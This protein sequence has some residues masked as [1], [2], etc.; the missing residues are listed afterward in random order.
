MQ[1]DPTA[2]RD[3]T[4][5]TVVRVVQR[6][7]NVTGETRPRYEVVRRYL[8]TGVKH[9]SLYHQLLD[10]ATDVWHARYVVVDSTGV[11][12]GLSSFLRA[13]L[14]DRVVM[15]VHFSLSSKSELG[16]NFLG[17]IDSGRFK[18]YALDNVT[19]SDRRIDGGSAGFSDSR[20]R[21]RSR[22]L[23]AGTRMHI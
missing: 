7:D 19:E 1:Y 10:L 23:E 13:A 15:P 5:L 9:T 6:F 3:S 2:R 14:G 12:A 11:G 21:T 22:V 4:A 16:W 20:P 18:D 17:I 8:W